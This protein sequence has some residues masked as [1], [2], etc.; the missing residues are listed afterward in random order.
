[1]INQRREMFI[2]M[3]QVAAEL[4]LPPVIF[5]GVAYLIWR[6]VSKRFA[7]HSQMFWPFMLAG[8]AVLCFID[9]EIRY[10]HSWSILVGF[11][12]CYRG[13]IL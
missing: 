7:L 10:I 8:F 12:C 3:L 9:Y 2:A 6:Y 1:M 5:A 4:L 13:S 11:L